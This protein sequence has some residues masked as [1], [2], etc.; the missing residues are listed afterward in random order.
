[1]LFRSVDAEKYLRQS[2]AIRETKEPGV[3]STFNTQSV[4]GAALLGQKKYSEA[5]PLLLR[6]YEGMK[7]VE[8]KIPVPNKLPL[9][10]ALERLVQLFDA[11]DKPDQAARWRKEFEAHKKPA[12]EPKQSKAK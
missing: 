11:W 3:W 12:G 2:L 4:L 8:N 9:S 5:E 1:M 10:E 7:Q 6:G